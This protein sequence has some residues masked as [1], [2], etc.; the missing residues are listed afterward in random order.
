M[1]LP[2]FF[3]H[4]PCL[5]FLC[6]IPFLHAEE[7]PQDSPDSQTH[8]QAA[9]IAETRAVRPGLPLAVGIKLTMDPGWHTYWRDPGE[10]GLATSI[11]W[12]LPDGWQASA[13]QWPKPKRFDT[14]G[15]I[16]YGY[17]D[18]T[19]LLVTIMP[20]MTVPEELQQITLRAR[21]D[22][23][24]CKDVCLPG[25][26][27]LELTLPITQ[28]PPEI[29]P[30]HAPLFAAARATLHQPPEN[31]IPIQPEGETQAAPIV[32]Q[33]DQ[34]LTGAEASAR[35]EIRSLWIAIL[36]AFLGGLILNL[37][38]CV[39]PVLSLKVLSLLQH[40]GNA[41]SE[42][43]REGIL[44]AVGVKGTFVA[45]ALILVALRSAGEELGWGFQ[46]QNPW[47][48]AALAV[49]FW[50]I[51]L[52]LLGVFTVGAGLVSMQN[53][54]TRVH[55]FWS[56][57]RSGALVVLVATPC[58]APFMGAAMGYALT[59][60]L[61]EVIVVF[62]A[63]GGGMALP[64]FLL[65]VFPAWLRWVPKPGAW[66]ETFKQ[67]LALPMSLAVVWLVW[68]L[69]LQLGIDAVAILLLILVFSGSAAYC[70]GRRQ[71]AAPG[72]H[73]WR[74]LEVVFWGVSLWLFFL[75]PQ[76][77][78]QAA[79]ATTDAAK[80]SKQSS[81][82]TSL[83]WE[84]YDEAKLEAYRKAGRVVLVNF[85][86]AW[87]L[88]CKANEAVAFNTEETVRF[89]KELGVVTMKA[90][91]TRRNTVITRALEKLGRR[92]VPVYALYLG[93]KPPVLLPQIL[94]AN[95]V[96]EAVL[97]EISQ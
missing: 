67:A 11:R 61:L 81:S 83:Q 6:L 13:I 78:P 37:M 3:R 97:Q 80:Q 88:T 94:T 96:K 14:A 55:S 58:T 57:L 19:L 64:Y 22:W 56:T 47:I 21:V 38:P 69:G 1:S 90:D 62:A 60:P 95:L 49:L 86:A 76:E 70:L 85:T 17:E 4:L 32:S 77:A 53:R 41:T 5:P 8:T 36:W 42:R 93:E 28:S 43:L 40:A 66:M 89:F 45:L 10:S 71:L 34:P 33:P 7:K 75:L 51:T 79:I 48:V 39:L 73:V 87:C 74:G 63:L 50:V 31:Y 18:E 59:R 44:F 68:V 16:S 12:N 92:S 30:V 25:Q 52:N 46:L 91:W 84:P 2:R 27:D 65:S 15:I 82:K 35:L 26:A 54:A 23:L 24:E 20:P 29:D 72:K 9:L